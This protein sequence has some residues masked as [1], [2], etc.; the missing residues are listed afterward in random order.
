MIHKVKL[1][2]EISLGLGT[3]WNIEYIIDVDYYKYFFYPDNF[4]KEDWNVLFLLEYVP[5]DSVIDYMLDFATEDRTITG[6]F[7]KP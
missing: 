1:S 6:E 2:K 4:Q 5:M 7:V 3:S